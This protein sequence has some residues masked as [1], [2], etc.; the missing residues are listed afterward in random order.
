M[1]GSISKILAVLVVGASFVATQPV[2]AKQL[3]DCSTLVTGDICTIN[4]DSNSIDVSAD[5]ADPDAVVTTVFGIPLDYLVKWEVLE[6]VEGL[7]VIINAHECPTSG[8]LMA[9][10]INDIELR[11]GNLKNYK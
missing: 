5:C 2:S 7:E 4:Y 6:V 1:K 11:Q 3:L 9:C 10:D 8:K